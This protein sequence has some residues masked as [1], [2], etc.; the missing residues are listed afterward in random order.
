MRGHLKKIDDNWFVNYKL[1]TETFNTPVDPTNISEEL[2]EG[3]FVLFDLN[4][5]ESM[6][7]ITYGTD[8][9]T[10]NIPTE[11]LEEVKNLFAKALTQNPTSN[12]VHRL[13]LDFCQRNSPSLE[14]SKLKNN[15]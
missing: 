7:T 14:M 4:E 5:D 8:T 1:L 2:E 10:L 6:A 12:D 11:D 3:T 9:V 15:D 13:I